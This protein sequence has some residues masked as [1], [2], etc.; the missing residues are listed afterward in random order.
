[1]SEGD[2]QLEHDHLQWA[3]TSHC[4]VAAVRR[5]GAFAVLALIAPESRGGRPPGSSSWSPCRAAGSC[6]AAPLALRRPRRARQ[7]ARRGAR[8]RQ[9]EAHPARRGRHRRPGRTA[10]QRVPAG[11][12]QQRAAR[13]RRH[14][15]APLQFVADALAAA[16][17]QVTAAFGFRD[18]ARQARRRL[19]DRRLWVATDDGSV[20]RPARSSTCSTRST[21]RPARPCSPAGPPRW[22]P[23]SSAGPRRGAARLRVARGPHGLRHRLLPRLRGRHRARLPPRVRRRPGVRARRGDAVTA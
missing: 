17:A 10:R 7:P 3:E 6:C 11:G 4:R 16:G 15:R 20:G 12:R 23:P 5:F 8:R 9:R 13:R 21:C 1:M 18:A 19:R 14:R 2:A 22:S